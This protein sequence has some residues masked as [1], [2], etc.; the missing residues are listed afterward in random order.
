MSYVTSVLFLYVQIC[1][2]LYRF[3]APVREIDID[4][5]G[6]VV[7]CAA[8]GIFPA[9]TLTW[10]TDPPA[11]AQLLQ[12]KTKAQKN[13]YGFYDIQ[14]SLRLTGNITTNHTY[15]CSITSDSN[16]KTAFL[17]GKGN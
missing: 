7:T 9:P 8:E 1:F 11:D 4:F 15:V 14:S 6:D 2:Y 12:N 13:K 10:S 16:R 17:K 3:V 5:S